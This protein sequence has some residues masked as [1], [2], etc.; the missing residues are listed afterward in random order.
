FWWTHLANLLEQS[1]R[2]QPDQLVYH[3][4]IHVY[5]RHPAQQPQH[6]HAAAGSNHSTTCTYLL[7]S[8]HEGRH[9]HSPVLDVSQSVLF[10]YAGPGN[11][12]Q[13]LAYVYL[14]GTGGLCIV[15]SHRF[16]VYP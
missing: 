2:F 4:R 5:S 11:Y 10:R 14:L 15:P 3:W 7:Q 6:T 9:W 8:I 16:L 12:G 1:A 13:P